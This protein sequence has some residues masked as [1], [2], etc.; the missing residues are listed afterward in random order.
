MKDPIKRYDQLTELNIYAASFFLE[1]FAKPILKLIVTGY[2]I[3][4]R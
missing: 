1:K 3:I 2:R 4:F